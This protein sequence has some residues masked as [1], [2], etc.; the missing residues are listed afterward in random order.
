MILNERSS[1]PKAVNI[2]RPTVQQTHNYN[3]HQRSNYSTSTDSSARTIS[4]ASTGAFINTPMIRQASIEDAPGLSFFCQNNTLKNKTSYPNIVEHNLSNAHYNQPLEKSPYIISPKSPQ[5]LVISRIHLSNFQQQRPTLYTTTMDDDSIITLDEEEDIL[6]PTPDNLSNPNR[7]SSFTP[8]FG[9][10]GNT[11][12]GSFMLRGNIATAL[13]PQVD[14]ARVYRKIEDLEIEKKSLLTLNQTL[15][16]VVKQQSHT[17][18]DLQRRLAS[19]ER[20]L[21]PGLDTSISKNGIM[22]QYYYISLYYI[23]NIYSSSI[24]SI[25]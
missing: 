17:I 10:M 3:I 25:R 2:I 15:E 22:V 8:G 21:T 7:L 1:N 24:I 4:T 11:G 23:D 13:K 5:P 6:R 16:T 12:L 9:I 14:E 18:E 19:I 20:P